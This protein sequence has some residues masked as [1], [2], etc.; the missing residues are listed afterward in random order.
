MIETAILSRRLLRRYL[1]EIFSVFLS[2]PIN[3]NHSTDEVF[4][5]NLNDD[6]SFIIDADIFIINFIH[7]SN[8][9]LAII[10]FF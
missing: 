8:I 1:V 6:D 4:K 7:V 2:D 9:L 10:Q 3:S 5:H